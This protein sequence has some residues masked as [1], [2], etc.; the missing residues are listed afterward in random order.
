MKNTNIHV[1]AI[2]DNSD[3]AELIRKML[4][5]VREPSFTFLQAPR[6]TEGLQLLRE[7]SF[8]IVLVDLKLPDSEG[9]NSVLQIREQSP[10]IP[11][12]VL[13]GLDDDEIALKALHLDVQDY[14]TKG[15]IDRNL[16]V[17]SIRYAI[18]RKRAVEAL[19]ISEARFRRLSESGIIGI[20]YFDA[21]GRISDGNDKFLSMIGVNR[22]D[23]AA[24]RIRRWGRLIPPD[25]HL[26]AREAAR[27]FRMTD[28]IIPYE[29]EYY[30]KDGSRYWGLFGAAKLDE[31]EDGIAFIVDITER[32]RLEEE[33]MYMA[34]HDVLT[35]LPNRRLFMELIH[36]ETAEARRNR[37]K[38][39]LLCIDL[40]RFKEVNDA[41]GHEA[42]DQFLRT[43]AERLR[44]TIRDSD[45]VARIGG[46]EFSIL[47]AG[48]TRPEDISDIARKILDAFREKCVIADH[49]F[50]I[51]AS[52]GI[53]I[54]PD[55]S[56]TVESLLQYADIALYHAKSRG[57][58][59]FEYYDPNIKR[60]SIEQLKF[61]KAMRR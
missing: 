34:H 59:T 60:R 42:G 58:N 12:I 48:I 13:T 35:G 39:G 46:D 28:R 24:G 56:D 41:L 57:R 33:I 23:L 36:F 7:G 15:Q 1:L 5:K 31:Q 55:D 30:S 20:V 6:L 32:K 37:T 47:L 4:E 18:E 10:T 14:L 25:W 21:A 17:R 38:T 54:Y 2:E 27:E 26:R 16:L 3:D 49:E 9:M 22:D 11:I 52:I 43:V 8:D 40:D 45:A 61:E 51:T 50:T 53:S 19:R 29:M 44:A